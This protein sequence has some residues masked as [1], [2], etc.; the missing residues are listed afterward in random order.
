MPPGVPITP[1]VYLMRDAHDEV[2]Y[3]GKAN[4]LRTRVRTY[5]LAEGDGRLRI[6]HL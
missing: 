1:G 6:P 2:L 3:V 4:N 5:F